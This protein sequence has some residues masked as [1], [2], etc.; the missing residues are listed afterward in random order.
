[1]LAQGGGDGGTALFLKLT[2]ADRRQH[3]H[4]AQALLALWLQHAHLGHR[5]VVGES[6]L[7]LRQGDP[8]FFDFDDP[9]AAPAEAE[10]MLVEQCQV[11]VQR[12]FAAV[13]M[14]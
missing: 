3:Q 13:H 5:R 7:D 6:L 12:R 2:L 10:A 4:C 14:R 1:V 11:I 9:V 8:F